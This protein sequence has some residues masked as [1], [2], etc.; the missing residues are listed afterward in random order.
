VAVFVFV[1]DVG[2]DFADVFVVYLDFESVA[3]VSV[4][5]FMAVF[6]TVLLLAMGM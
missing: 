5:E 1:F 4:F 6:A 3:V 2:F